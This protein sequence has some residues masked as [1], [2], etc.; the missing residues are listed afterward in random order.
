MIQW[1]QFNI[2]SEW[3]LTKN[4]WCFYQQILDNWNKSSFSME[5]IKIND[6]L[7]W[8]ECKNKYVFNEKY[9]SK[10]D[11]EINLKSRATLEEKESN[12][13]E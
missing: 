6:F 9:F 13:K 4:N 8:N 1:N 5:L 2:I 7:S 12:K 10:F 11:I 3:I